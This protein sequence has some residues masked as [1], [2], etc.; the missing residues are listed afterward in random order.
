MKYDKTTIDLGNDV[1][2]FTDPS[3]ASGFEGARI[4]GRNPTLEIDPDMTLI[5]TQGQYARHINNTLGTYSE[6]VGNHLT[7]SAPKAQIVQS[8]KPGD[9]EG[10][11]VNNIRCALTRNL[12]N[13]ELVILQG[14]E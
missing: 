14:S 5:A 12:G 13:D 8:Y 1:Q 11:A 10:H 9:R 6:T 3:K 7:I 2:L 4:V